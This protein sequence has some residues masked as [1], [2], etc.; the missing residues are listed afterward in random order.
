[1]SQN[2]KTANVQMEIFTQLVNVQYKMKLT[3]RELHQ[4]TSSW[5]AQDY[6]GYIAEMHLYDSYMPPYI[7]DNGELYYEL[8]DYMLE[9][10]EKYNLYLTGKYK[11][12]VKQSGLTYKEW[13]KSVHKSFFHYYGDHDLYDREPSY[14]DK[15]YIKDLNQKEILTPISITEI[16]EKLHDIIPK[17]KINFEDTE[18]IEDVSKFSLPDSYAKKKFPWLNTYN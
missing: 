1:M 16:P 11:K 3:L 6:N 12:E 9:L 10:E 17:Y 13:I 4:V 15:K 18:V 7:L 14:K 8:I 5:Y 2:V